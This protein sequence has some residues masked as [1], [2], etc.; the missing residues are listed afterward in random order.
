MKRLLLFTPF[1]FLLASCSLAGDVTPP[2]GYQPPTPQ[3]TEP[4]LAGPLY[5][6]EAPSPARGAE[7][8]AGKCASCHGATGLGDGADAGQLRDQ[9]IAVP[10]LG[11]P[12]FA[13]LASPERWYTIVTQGNLKRFMPP[14]RSLSDQ[15]RWDVVAYALSLSATPEDLAAGRVLYEANCAKCHTAGEVVFTDQVRMARLTHATIASTIAEG[16]GKMPAFPDLSETQRRQ[17]AVYVR[18]LSFAAGEASAAATAAAPAGG[19]PPVAAGPVLSGTVSISGTVSAPGGVDVPAGLDVTLYAFGQFDPH[20]LLAFTLTAQTASDGTFAFADVPVQAG[21]VVGAALE[22]QNVLYGSRAADVTAGAT[23]LFLPIEI[24]EATSDTSGLVV[25]RHHLIFTFDAPGQVSVMEMYAISNP[26]EQTVA[27][28]PGEALVFFPLPLGAENLEVQSGALGERFLSVPGGI[29]DTEP[30]TPGSGAYQ[31]TFAYTLPYEDRLDF[32]QVVNLN[33]TAV[34]VLV[35]DSGLE[36][37]GDALQ[38]GGTFQG[39]AFRRYDAVDLPAERMLTFTLAGVPEMPAATSPAVHND[40]R[41]NL[42]IGLGALGVVLIALGVWFY[43]RN[44]GDGEDDDGELLP[45]GEAGAEPALQDADS[46]MDAIIALDDQF[47]TGQIPE[48]AYQ[49]RRAGLKSDLRQVLEA[50]AP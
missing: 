45:E 42:A 44:R 48:A 26:G 33:T 29:A 41:L 21:Q 15:E 14:F 43:L 28:A 20:P 12:D 34:T 27:P 17:L 11:L 19:M 40:D 8:Y 46:L 7:I 13:R 2:P 22:Y 32:S 37:L 16:K 10:P 4:P 9:N 23:A 6:S 3:P 24:Y 18:S 30:V 1:I 50:Q 39:M 49:R 47:R 36:V 25:D 31:V 35:P 5:P 38:D